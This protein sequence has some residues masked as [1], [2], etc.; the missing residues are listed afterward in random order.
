MPRGKSQGITI[1]FIGTGEMEPDPAT[2]LIEEFLTETVKSED[3]VKFIFPLVL[4]E[5]SDSLAGLTE[6][7]R[8]SK[9][10]YEVIT[11]TEDKKRRPFMQIA[12]AASNQYLVTDVFTQMET[13]LVEA[14]N[15]A[16]MVLWDDKRDAE[17]QSI[18]AKFL[19]ADI[20]V[21]DLTN[22]LAVLGVEEQGEEEE[23]EQEEEEEEEEEEEGEDEAE[24]VR[25]LE[26]E[27]VATAL[28][29]RPD[30]MK[31]NHAQVK[32]V[33]VGMG[34]PA[35][36]AREAMIV[37]ILE[38]QGGAGDTV[39]VPVQPQV[40]TAG[41]VDLTSANLFLGGLEI[42]LND[43]GK[44]FMEGLDDWLTKFSTAAEGFA[45]NTTPEEQMPDEEE[46]EQEE[47]IPRRR[48][49]RTPR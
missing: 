32:E 31:L 49:F 13:I 37:A 24:P 14:P 47:E 8:K 43:F 10:T 4:N 39:P 12:Q 16:L 15:A 29:T 30:L 33:A 44:R 21:M 19:D 22:G 20:K 5:F 42:T 3:P 1:G 38:A 6:M 36:K 28:Y 48:L 26:A 27:A 18:V 2:D 46:E 34:L 9:I 11:N 25:E 45:F 23:E 40:V 35:R 41:A 7:A 17:L